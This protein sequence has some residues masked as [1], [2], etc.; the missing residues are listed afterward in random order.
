MY[1][2]CAEK[3]HPSNEEKN[4]YNPNMD[5]W[6]SGQ[7]PQL[8]AVVELVEQDGHLTEAAAVL[9]IPQST[10]SRR[11][12]GLE[13]HLGVS[14]VVPDGRALSLTEQAR[15]LVDSIRDP[16]H[17]IGAA[18]TEITQTADPDHGVIRFGFPLTMG[19]G[20][21]PDLLAAFSAQHPGI[22]LELKQAH[23]AQ[24]VDDLRRGSLDL[25]II[26]PPP[27]DIP[28]E[29]LA[30]Q[31]II[32]AVPAQHQLADR[33]S[34]SLAQ[35]SEER[36]IANPNTYNLR[37][38]TNEW[39]RAVGFTPQVK[40]EVTEFSTIREFVSRGM[41]VALIPANGR[42]MDG[43][44]EVAL[45]G[46]GYVRDVSLC[47][48]VRKPSRV[49]RRLSDFIAELLTVRNDLTSANTAGGGTRSGS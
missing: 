43:L 36:F 21:I 32:A 41:G 16:L 6:I 49:V 2:P 9:G 11:I 46:S 10:M 30:R 45:R 3:N 1:S 7:F 15:K 26:I 42:L 27:G 33:G 17:E 29:V 24:L 48:A 5:E 25:A 14:L 39:C 22:R 20:Q 31:T 34:V 23:G 37:E 28:H 35:L 18:I 4:Q 47:S 44:A 38:L 12:H 13:D 19:T 8:A 40:T